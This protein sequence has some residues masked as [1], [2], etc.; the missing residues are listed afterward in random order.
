MPTYAYRCLDDKTLLELSRNVNNRDDLV[1]CPQCN[2][3]M[4]REY[5]P[6][7]VIFKGSGFYSTG[8]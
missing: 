1:E 5:Q 6:N 8:G 3:T 7:P 2:N 4:V